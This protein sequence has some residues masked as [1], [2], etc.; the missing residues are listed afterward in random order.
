MNESIISVV[1][2]VVCGALAACNNRDG[3]KCVEGA[4]VACVCS[5]GTAG[6]QTCKAGGTYG[7]CSCDPAGA[8]RGVLMDDNYFCR[9]TTT[10]S[11]DQRPS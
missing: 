11:A 6:A 5:T 8:A 1:A 3:S 7:A 4:S 10:T 2:V 9:A